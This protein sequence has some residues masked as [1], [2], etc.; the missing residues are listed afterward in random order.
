MPERSPEEYRIAY[1][2]M[3]VGLE[4]AMPSYSG[5]LGVL[6][7]DALRAAADL[8]LPLLAVTL[9][10]RK[11]YF[12]QRLDDAGRQDEAPAEW[13]PEQFLEPLAPR[14]AIRMEG[15]E[16]QIR[17]WRY[18]VRGV[19]G[20]P[21]PVYFLDT[22]LPENDAA[23]RTIT[24][25][26]YGGDS[27]YRL[28]Q[29]L[30][31]GMGGIAVLRALGHSG[32]DTYHMNEGHSGFL[33][34]AL[35]REETAGREPESIT[36][37][38]FD[39]VRRRCVFTVHTPVAAGHDVF[40][41]DLLERVLGPEGMRYIARVPVAADGE[42]N[43]TRFALFFCRTANAVSMRHGQISR[44]M[45][46]EYP[47][48]AITNGVH[49]TT[50]ACRPVAALFDNY[51]PLWRRDSRYLRH[52][53]GIPAE[54]IMG[55][56]R[57]A[58]AEL[59]AEVERRSGTRLDPHA[60]TIGFARRSTGYK[61]AGLLFTDMARLRRLAARAGPVQLVYA[62]KAHP[63]DE[64][65]QAL[66]ESIFAAAASLD[67]AVPVVY[68]E[69]YDIDLARLLCS[70]CD[71][72]LNNPQKPLEASGTSGMKAAVNGVPSLSTLDGW[73][74]E[75]HVE[76]VTG[77]A[78][79][80]DWRAPSDTAAEAASLY[81]KLEYT[82]LPLFYKRPGAYAEV[83]RYAM[84]VNGAFFNAHRMVHQYVRALYEPPAET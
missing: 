25:I 6:A 74:I 66:I 81:D 23:D 29:E 30:V 53:V 13:S 60:M 41:V 34:L 71:L 45:F 32:L 8:G 2:S 64:S 27:V 43:L 52:A 16:V 69:D 1:F 3:E 22:D 68:L 72:W 26:L 17:A 20:D 18:T 46:P 55:A 50:W 67:G 83:M 63:R 79:G 4:S 47:I 38:D 70:G 24:D 42:F 48:E 57:Q 19:S 39:A 11:G 58:K 59:L 10:H 49:I 37:A 5:G 7:G 51:I 28:R 15:R 44:E 76:G 40:P 73:W 31:L 21:V 77:W 78:I 35:L 12:R 82:I 61:R 54:E 80:E 84:A 9:L 75:G 65:G 36:A 14:A 62:G 33:T 56:H